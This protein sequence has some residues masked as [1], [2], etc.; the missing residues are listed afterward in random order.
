MKIYIEILATC[1]FLGAIY[2]WKAGVFFWN[3]LFINSYG[4]KAERSNREVRNIRV[5]DLMLVG[6][7]ILEISLFIKSWKK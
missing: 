7:I 5:S 3:F 2:G 6:L 1:I 4:L